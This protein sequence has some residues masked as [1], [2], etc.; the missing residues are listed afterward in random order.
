MYIHVQYNIYTYTVQYNIYTYTVQCNIY[1]YTVQYNIYTY[2]VQYNIYTY[3]VQYNIYTYNVQYNIYTYQTSSTWSHV[4]YVTSTSLTAGT[5]HE[6]SAER[7]EGREEGRTVY[8]KLWAGQLYSVLATLTS[9]TQGGG[10]GRGSCI[11][12]ETPLQFPY[13]STPQSSGEG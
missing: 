1:T 4:E 11:W 8:W 10:A 9:S 5:Y 3:T 6:D 13:S 12:R 2:T 7:R